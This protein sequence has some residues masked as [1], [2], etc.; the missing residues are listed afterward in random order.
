MDF[1]SI[2]FY[3]I[4]FVVAMALVGFFMNY[5]RTAPAST[6]LAALE[7]EPV[8][9][10]VS[11]TESI[12]KLDAHDDGSVTLER[13]GLLLVDGE[14]VNLVATVID[15]KITIAE[16]KGK[17]SAVG[18]KESLYNGHATL[19]FFPSGIKVYIRYESSVAGQWS[20]FSFVN[21]SGNRVVKELRY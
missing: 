4:A 9:D 1:T 3:T 8:Q 2:E 16:K 11:A 13:K 19:A 10:D 18:G 20:K 7:L 14:T 21:K 12:I 5:K 15:D 17:A 6:H